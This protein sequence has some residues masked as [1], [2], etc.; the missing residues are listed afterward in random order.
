MFAFGNPYIKE[1]III[2]E[3]QFFTRSDI[4]FL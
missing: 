3:N 1:I 2:I 4:I